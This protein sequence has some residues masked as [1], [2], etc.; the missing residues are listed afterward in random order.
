M[1]ELPRRQ[2][3]RQRR[4]RGLTERQNAAISPY[5]QTT[6]GDET[7]TSSTGSTTSGSEDDDD[8]ANDDNALLEAPSRNASQ[9]QQLLRQQSPA[10]HTAA[11]PTLTHKQQTNASVIPDEVITPYNMR[12]TGFTLSAIDLSPPSPKSSKASIF[13]LFDFSIPSSHQADYFRSRAST[14]LIIQKHFH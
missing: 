9:Q 6:T 7:T 10:N 2:R 8:E 12:N 1:T 14:V 5:L 11:T 13:S 3:T 4:K